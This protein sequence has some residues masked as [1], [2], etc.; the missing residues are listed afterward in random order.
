[1]A[2]VMNANGTTL[3]KQPDCSRVRPT[4]LSAMPRPGRLHLTTSHELRDLSEQLARGGLA[5][6]FETKLAR[7]AD[8]DLGQR[9]IAQNCRLMIALLRA[10]HDGAFRQAGHAECERM[11]RVLA[12]VRKDD[13][14]IPD[15]RPDG[16]TDDQ[17]EVRAVVTELNPLLRSFKNWFL[18]H[19]VPVLWPHSRPAAPC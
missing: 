18:L 13:D 7:L 3:L 14:A 10:A 11:L 6:D 1:M 15:Y 12:Y 4:I 2:T 17:Q 16:F 19:Q 5:P 9:F 8:G